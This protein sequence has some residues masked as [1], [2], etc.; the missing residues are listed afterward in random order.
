MADPYQPPQ[1]EPPAHKDQCRPHINGHEF[2]AGPGRRADCAIKCPA[3]AI[4]RDGK[5]IYERRPQETAGSR[6]RMPV[7][8]IGNKEKQDKQ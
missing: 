2:E 7:S 4:D 3:C 5:R 1:N 6:A 8:E